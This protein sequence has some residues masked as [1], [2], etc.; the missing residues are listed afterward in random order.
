MTEETK[1]SA[2]AHVLT[3]AVLKVNG[4]EP[5]KNCY[6]FSARKPR[7]HDTRKFLP[8]FQFSKGDMWVSQYIMC[9]LLSCFARSRIVDPRL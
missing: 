3:S 6:R 2:A 5:N 8:V 4:C 1:V 7:P 9:D